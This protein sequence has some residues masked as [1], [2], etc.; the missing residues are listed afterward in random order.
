VCVLNPLSTPSMRKNNVR[1]T[2]TD[3]VDTFVIAKTLMMKDSFRFLTLTDLDYI[4]LKELG[5]FRQKTVKQRTRLKIQLTSYMDQV[6]PEL[7]YF[8]KSGVHQNSVYALLK[9]APTPN[10]IASM[11]LTH[12]AHI[13]ECA[14]HGHFNKDKARELRVLAQ[15]SV[16]INDSSLSI[17]ITQTI[18]QIELLDR[19]L[20]HTELEMANIVTCLHSVLMTIPGIGF[21]NGGMILGEIGDIHRFSTPGKL[22]AFA[23]L[24]PS[25]YQSGNFQAKKTRMSKSGSRVLRYAIVNAAHNVVKNNAT[26]KAYYDAK[27]TEGRTHYNALGHCA[28][29][30]VRVIWKMLTDEVEFNLE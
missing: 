30:L 8:F 10:S 17:Q 20:F 21:I 13:L 11:H 1:K 15:K 12:L 7:Q 24:D 16:G 22:L 3:K 26:F 28:G 2:K 19:Q 23:G 29:K 5:R 14:S 27:R 25:V 6:F 4:E 18:E 9:E